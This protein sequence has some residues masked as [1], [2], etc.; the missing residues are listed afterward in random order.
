MLHVVATQRAASHITPGAREEQAPAERRFTLDVL[1]V[2]DIER[3]VDCLEE[4]A[5]RRV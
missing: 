2:E 5:V 1:F 3:E 4:V